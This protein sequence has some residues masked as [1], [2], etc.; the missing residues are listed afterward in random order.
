MDDPAAPVDDFGELAEGLEAGAAAGAVQGG[1]RPATPARGAGEGEQALGVDPLVPDG[2]FAHPGKTARLGAVRG[3]GRER[4]ATYVGLAVA[5]LAGGDGDAGGQALDVPFEGAG[6]GLVEVVEVEQ[7]G[8]FRGG[9]QA[10]VEQVRVAAELDGQAGV[11]GR[12]QIGGEYGGGTAQEGERRGGHPAVPDRQQLGEAVPSLAL[13]HAD[14]VGPVDGGQPAGVLG[15]RQAFARF[16]AAPGAVGG[17]THGRGRAGAG[18]TRNH[19]IGPPWKRTRHLLIAVK[20][21]A[22]ASA[23]PGRA[24]G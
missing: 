12:G 5:V 20:A 14:G 22:G 18:H 7:Q 9:V 11:R 2:E 4:G 16:L 23:C 15:A 1:L 19:A 8:A 6:E 17:G 21:G 10:E 3:G 24:N 13:Q